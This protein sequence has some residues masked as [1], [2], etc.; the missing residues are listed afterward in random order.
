MIFYFTG[1]GNSLQVAKELLNSKEELI[2]IADA[3]KNDRYEYEVIKGEN[4]GFVFPVYFYTLPSI[5]SD[6][7]KKLTISNISTE[8]VYGVI[9]CGGGISQAA[10]VLKNEL[11]KRK[12]KLSYVNSVLMPDNSMLFYQIPTG[13]KVEE[14]LKSAKGI[15]A[16]VKNDIENK[17]E[18]KIGDNRII[19]NMLGAAYNFCKKTAK[20]YVEDTCIGCGLCEKNCP[21]GVIKINNGKPRWEKD[22]CCKCSACINR[23]PVKAIQYGKGTKKRNRYVNPTIK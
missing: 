7:I 2:S 21:E 8:Y 4:V 11:S 19:S 10:S 3:I 23:C 13:E 6:F 1:T 22:N 14:R 12:I 20:F 16:S 5:V 18:S 9:T 15:I 17:K